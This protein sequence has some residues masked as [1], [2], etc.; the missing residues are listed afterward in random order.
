MENRYHQCHNL[1]GAFAV[2]AA[3]SVMAGPVLL[4]DDVLDSG[5]TMT[6][7]TALLRQAGSGLWV[8]SRSDPLYPKRLKLRAS[9][10]RQPD[11]TRG[12]PVGP[13]LAQP[14]PAS[15]F[16]SQSID[17]RTMTSRSS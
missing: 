12:S 13:G 14:S 15:S 9:V 10:V 5:W 6:I 1:D 17:E 4:V 3:K 7:A 8:Q 11:A 16:R 2:Q